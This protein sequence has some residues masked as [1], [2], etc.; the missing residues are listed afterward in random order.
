[1]ALRLATPLEQVVAQMKD[2][3]YVQDVAEV[4]YTIVSVHLL[5]AA[6]LRI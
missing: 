4:R 6:L 1:M 5:S 3:K 2:E